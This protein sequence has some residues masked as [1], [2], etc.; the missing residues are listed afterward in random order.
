M[1]LDHFGKRI[2]RSTLF[3]ASLV[4]ALAGAWFALDV[5]VAPAAIPAAVTIA[6]MA[7]VL[8]AER[9]FPRVGTSAEPGEL[10]ADLGFVA[11]SSAGDVIT[12]S[13]LFG[14]VAALAAWVPADA[15]AGLPLG[16]GAAGVLV[17]GGLGD[18]WA[19]RFGHEWGWWWKLH[20]VHHTPRRMVALNNFRLHPLDLALKLLFGVTP[21]LLLGFSAEAIAIAGAVK[22]LTVAFQHADVDLRHGYL[23]LVFATNSVHRWHHSALTDEGNANY[24]GVLSIFDLAFGTYRV[25]PEHLEPQRMGLYVERHDPLNDRQTR[26]GFGLHAE[27]LDLNELSAALEPEGRSAPG[28]R[29]TG[30]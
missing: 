20:A 11:L 16:V 26:G 24:G 25:P 14:M 19:H 17:T 18:Y 6:M 8:A 4:L 12:R 1:R 9:W 28:D 7:V 29:T 10:R 23:N 15:L 5:G 3:P 30:S 2:V 22:G 27:T 13:V 21:V